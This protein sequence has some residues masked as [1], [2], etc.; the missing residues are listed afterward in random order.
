[1]QNK[2]ELQN[3]KA[4]EHLLRLAE[5][6][7]KRRGESSLDRKNPVLLEK[8][9]YLIY[10]EGE[11]TEP[12]YFKKFKLSNL[13][14]EIFGKGENTLSLVNSAKKIADLAK[15]SNKGY[16]K[17]WCVFDADPK[18]SNPNQLKNFNAA[19]TKA[20]N[21]GFEVAYSN[22]AFEYWL[23]LHFEDHQ[24]GSMHRNLYS[25]KINSWLNKFSIV[26]ADNKI[27]NQDFFDKLED[28]VYTDRKG[29]TFTRIQMACK[30]AEKNYNKLNHINPGKE[31]SSTTVFKLVKELLKFSK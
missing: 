17:I 18:P 16:D 29:N 14:I 23:I 7:A 12:S 26:Y 31:E 19:I 10:C 1:M 28:I 6:K 27:I 11:N 20:L 5:I 25:S 9:L 24:G 15:K 21:L 22:Q 3:K 2:K 4:Q 8:P 30:R 13:A